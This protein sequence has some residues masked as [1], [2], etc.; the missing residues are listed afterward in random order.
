METTEVG[1]VLNT[2]ADY[3]AGGNPESD[4]AARAVLVADG[5]YQDYW[6]PE[7]ER[8]R[9]GVEWTG[10]RGPEAELLANALRQAGRLIA[11]GG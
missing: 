10:L 1:R 8:F 11:G 2:L 4:A 9:Q 5:D 6:R 3:F 7:I